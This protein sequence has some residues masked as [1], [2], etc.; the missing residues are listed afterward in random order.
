MRVF[1]IHQLA[2]PPWL[3]RDW[4]AFKRGYSASLPLQ[5]LPDFKGIETY[6]EY[7]YK[8]P[9]KLAAPPWLQRDWDL[10]ISSSFSAWWPC[11]TSLTSKGLR[12]SN[13]L[14]LVT[15]GLAAPP[16]LQRDWDGFCLLICGICIPCS[17]SLTS[18]GLR[19]L[20]Y[21]PLKVWLYLQHLPD[22]KGIE[23]VVRLSLRVVL[24]L[25]HLPDFKG[26][27]TLSLSLYLLSGFL[28][29]LPDFKGIETSS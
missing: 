7:W 22:F 3:Q 19:R 4:D 12:P 8:R 24:H 28:Q 1:A 9:V 15:N 21:T 6:W 23:T 10:E 2:A 14:L 13:G 25:Q 17:T 5:H 11:S 18:K 16:W 29:H 20:G 27:E 26:I